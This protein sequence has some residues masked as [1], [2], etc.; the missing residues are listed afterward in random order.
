MGLMFCNQN[1]EFAPF[2]NNLIINILEDLVFHLINEIG[3][4]INTNGFI[5]DQDNGQEIYYQGKQIKASID[6]RNPALENDLYGLFD[7]VFDGKFMAMMLGYYLKKSEAQGLIEP[8]SMT[9]QIAEIPYYNYLNPIKTRKTRVVVLCENHREYNSNFYYQKGLKYSDMILRIGGNYNIDLSKFDS[10]PE[11]S[12]QQTQII[13]K[14]AND[15]NKHIKFGGSAEDNIINAEKQ[16]DNK[17]HWEGEG[18]ID[19]FDGT[20]YQ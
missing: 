11:E 18:S 20:E 14:S 5:Y 1:N 9:E 10:I 6:P 3:I 12:I 16:Y 17:N 4:G 7:P 15:S 8:I 2:S 13:V 19:Y